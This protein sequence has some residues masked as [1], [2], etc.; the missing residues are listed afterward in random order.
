MK[1]KG[2]QPQVLPTN[3]ARN[4]KRTSNDFDSVRF[5]QFKVRRHMPLPANFVASLTSPSTGELFERIKARQSSPNG[6]ATLELRNEVRPIDLFCY[7]GARFGAPNGIQ[8]LLR[9]D[10]SDN[11]IHWDW[12]LLYEETLIAFWGTNFRTDLLIFGDLPFGDAEKQELIEQ[13]RDDLKNH[14]QKMSEVRGRLEHWTEFVNPYW[15]LSQAITGL[16]K[17]LAQL[18]LVS[19]F[20]SG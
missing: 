18:D 20:A 8:N 19:S 15:R 17:E 11:L 5:A 3:P 9:K 1:M 16:R 10:D 2:E 4:P 12:T 6:G 13:I 14:G 7:F